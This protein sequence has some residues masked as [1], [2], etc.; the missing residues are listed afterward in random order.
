MI[1]SAS[2][3]KKI[4]KG[5]G[6]RGE[7]LVLFINRPESNRTHLL[8][9]RCTYLPKLNDRIQ[10]PRQGLLLRIIAFLPMD[11]PT[12]MRLRMQLLLIGLVPVVLN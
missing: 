4:V 12:R 3:Y 5:H 6:S 2:S 11:M 7:S 10:P 1:L 9:T 8:M